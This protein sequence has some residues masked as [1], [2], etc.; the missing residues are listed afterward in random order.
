MCIRDRLNRQRSRLEI[1]AMMDAWVLAREDT[2]VKSLGVGLAKSG[3]R[4][5]SRDRLCASR[6]RIV[7]ARVVGS[8]DGLIGRTPGHRE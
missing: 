1:A 3:R 2:S 8:S 7:E 6:F 5:N 4:V